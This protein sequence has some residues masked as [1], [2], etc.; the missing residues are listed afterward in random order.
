MR[1]TITLDPDVA[2]L[3]EKHMKERGVPFKA[4]VN[5]ALRRGLGAVGDRPAFRT[6]T[7]DLGPYLA[8]VTHANRLAS[9]LEDD[10]ILS[11]LEQ[12]R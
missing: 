6:K 10:A 11:K 2:A 4:A 7:H 3:V 9:D 12:G 1:T 5:D 8:D